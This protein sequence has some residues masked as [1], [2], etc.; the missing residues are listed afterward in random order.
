MQFRASVIS[1][2]CRDVFV[3]GTMD[4]GEINRNVLGIGGAAVSIVFDEFSPSTLIELEF[5]KTLD[6]MRFQV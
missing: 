3:N 2:V 5:C 6:E 4:N 1:N